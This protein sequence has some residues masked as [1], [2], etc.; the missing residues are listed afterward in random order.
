MLIS[1][2]P[3][4]SGHGNVHEI[5]R[6]LSH[7]ISESPTN[8]QLY[9]ERAKL[10]IKHGDHKQALDD[11]AQVEKLD[12]SID[13][14]L[15]LHA[16]IHSIQK[17]WLPAKIALDRYI[18]DHPGDP[19]PYTM[20][21]E[22]NQ[23]LGNI[24]ASEADLNKAINLHP[25]PPLKLY[26]RYIHLLVKNGRND[27]ALVVYSQAEKKFG[28]IP[29]LL[30]SKARMLGQIHK[31]NEASDVYALLRRLYPKLSFDWWMEESKLWENHDPEKTFYALNKARASWMLLPA[32][33][34]ALPHY[35][36]RYNKINN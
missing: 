18:I 8:P 4:C 2:A 33:T 19:L 1:T 25:A 9:L 11:I 28:H 17:K 34:R 35:Q 36:A 13:R 29:S 14:T 16:E 22:A 6:T 12:P 3:F 15:I 7:Q 23:Q 31:Y 32:R 10:L 20:R 5:I 24:R 30:T 27:Q 26:L 21:S